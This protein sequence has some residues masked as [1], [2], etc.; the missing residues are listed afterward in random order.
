MPLAAQLHAEVARAIASAN[1]E[2]AG[3]ASDRLIDYIELFTH[4]TTD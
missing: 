4:A 2:A 1:E 3:R